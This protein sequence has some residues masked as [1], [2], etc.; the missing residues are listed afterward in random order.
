MIGVFV[1]ISG[2]NNPPKKSSALNPGSNYHPEIP[3][4]GVPTDGSRAIENAASHVCFDI[5]V[6]LRLRPTISRPE[7]RQLSLVSV[8]PENPSLPSTA[9]Q[10]IFGRLRQKV[11]GLNRHCG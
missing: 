1:S 2:L 5:I 7:H 3:P 9:S 6:P 10:T 11:G 8:A 4:S